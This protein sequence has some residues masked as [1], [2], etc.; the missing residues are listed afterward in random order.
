[1]SGQFARR[2]GAHENAGDPSFWSKLNQ[3]TR[4][5]FQAMLVSSRIEASETR[6]S[7]T[8]ARDLLPDHGQSARIRGTHQAC[9]ENGRLD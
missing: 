1:M 8:L 3:R 7:G 6:C 4:F 2:I 5:E 9:A